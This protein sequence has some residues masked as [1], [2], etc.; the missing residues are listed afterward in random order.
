[1]RNILAHVPKKDKQH[2]AEQI[3]LIGMASNAK[4]ARRFAKEL[5]N[6][7]GTQYPKVIEV[8]EGGLEDSLAY[9]SFPELDK[10]KVSSTNLM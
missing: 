5:S 8:L 9:F 10:R 3:K 4:E 1:M 2:F 6:T 7:Y